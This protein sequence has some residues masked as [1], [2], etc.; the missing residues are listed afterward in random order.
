LKALSEL[1][2]GQN[3]SI[4]VEWGKEKMKHKPGAW[5]PPFLI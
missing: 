1:P 5:I 3:L 4:L 2:S